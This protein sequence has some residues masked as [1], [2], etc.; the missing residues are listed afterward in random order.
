MFCF[1]F[2]LFSFFFNCHYFFKYLF[3]SFFF[4]DSAYLWKCKVLVTQSC[5][6]LC[7]PMYS[8]LP[9][10]SVY[11]ILQGRIPEWI[12]F[13]FSRVSSQP[14]KPRPPLLQ[15]DSLVFKSPGKPIFLYI[16]PI[17]SVSPIDIAPQFF[18]QNSLE[19][20][21]SYFL[22][23][24]NF[25]LYILVIIIAL[26]SESH[27]LSLIVESTDEFIKGVFTCVTF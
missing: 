2:S 16:S 17:D 11:G 22:Y 26:F 7:D 13:S 1:C 24:L 8:S 25:S 5:L 9:G 3:C 14:I 6:T 12:A 27:T 19:V 20:I 15:V 10:S 4:S 18:S 23:I 21:V